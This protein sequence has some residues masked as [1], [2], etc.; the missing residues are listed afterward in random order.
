MFRHF[1]LRDRLACALAQVNVDLPAQCRVRDRH[2]SG[3]RC[4][5]SGPH[6]RRRATPKG[7]DG[8]HLEGVASAVGQAAEGGRRRGGADGGPNIERQRAAGAAPHLVA[9][10]ATGCG[11]TQIRL[12]IADGGRQARGRCGLTPS[13]QAPEHREQPA[14]AAQR[15]IGCSQ[16]DSRAVPAFHLSQPCGGLAAA[17]HGDGRGNAVEGAAR[18]L[19]GAACGDMLASGSSHGDS[20][21]LPSRVPTAERPSIPNQGRTGQMTCCQKRT[22]LLLLTQFR[23]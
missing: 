10:G 1:E 11:P 3:R 13:G 6:A 2:R 7:R 9:G 4:G 14:E 8:A 16:C 23:R 19:C 5:Q 17:D 21:N 18:R 15:T 20:N 22:D 12:A